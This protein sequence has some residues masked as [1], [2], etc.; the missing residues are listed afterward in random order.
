[1][2]AVHL[3]PKMG[4]IQHLASGE[5]LWEQNICYFMSLLDSVQIK[6]NSGQVSISDITQVFWSILS[7]ET[8]TGQHKSKNLTPVGCVMDVSS[9]APLIEDGALR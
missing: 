8:L 3:L 9:H 1:M 5:I 4:C 2:N 6:F 7:D